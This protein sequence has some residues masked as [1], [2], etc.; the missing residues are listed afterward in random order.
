VGL[1][2]INQPLEPPDAY[3]AAGD[4]TFGRARKQTKSTPEKR[5]TQRT[6]EL[7]ANLNYNLLMHRR[8]VLEDTSLLASLPLMRLLQQHPAYEDV[9]AGGAVVAAMRESADS[10]A[11]V[12][13]MVIGR[14]QYQDVGEEA[15]YANARTLDNLRIRAASTPTRSNRELMHELVERYFLDRSLWLTIG[16]GEASEQLVKYVPQAAAANGVEYFRRTEFWQFA[17]KL[18]KCKDYVCARHIRNQMAV[19][20]HGLTAT[21]LGLFPVYPAAFAPYADQVFGTRHPWNAQA[22]ETYLNEPTLVEGEL[23]R[24]LDDI[25]YLAVYLEPEDI[26][27]IRSCPEY[28]R[29]MRVIRSVDANQAATTGALRSTHNESSGDAAMALVLLDATR[30]YQHFVETVVGYR[31]QARTEDW[32]R[33]RRR[34]RLLRT[35]GWVMPGAAGLVSDIVPPMMGASLLEGLAVSTIST[36]LASACVYLLHNRHRTLI[37]EAETAAR[38]AARMLFRPSRQVSVELYG[39]LDGSYW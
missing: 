27:E 31:I 29:Y 36:P 14:R 22:E 24:T 21:T 33:I 2:Y 25:R 15:I 1:D 6:T 38:V 5:I 19:L 4:P 39:P 20:A 37:G 34:S 12:A 26:L 23:R 28:L 35:V 10:F 17:D 11:E 3:W 7:K 30:A 13:D 8:L 32:R 9:F 18:D 16:L